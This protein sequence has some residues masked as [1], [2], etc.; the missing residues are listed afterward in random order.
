GVR[1]RVSNVRA[2]RPAAGCRWPAHRAGHQLLYESSVDGA[3]LE[4]IAE[5]SP[6]VRGRDSADHHHRGA[7]VLGSRE[8]R[9][10]RSAHDCPE[11]RITKA[12]T[13]D[14]APAAIDR[15]TRCRGWREMAL[16]SPPRRA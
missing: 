10:S 13:T 12:P 8:T 3:A 5:R 1:A 2:V 4:H 6:V 9:R 7:R 11:A 16:R 15:A 14:L